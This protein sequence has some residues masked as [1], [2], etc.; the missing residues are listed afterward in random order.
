M[1]VINT[2]RQ[3]VGGKRTVLLRLDIELGVF[4]IAM[5][6]EAMVIENVT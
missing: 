6:V 5:E 4:C 1:Y 3:R 2:S